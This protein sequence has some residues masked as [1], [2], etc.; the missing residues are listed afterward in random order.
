MVELLDQVSR[1][2][3][4]LLCSIHATGGAKAGASKGR[5]SSS[6]G[7]RKETSPSAMS[8]SPGAHDHRGHSESDASVTVVVV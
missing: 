4:G 5:P 8:N 6:R 2:S 7:S 3:R 1:L